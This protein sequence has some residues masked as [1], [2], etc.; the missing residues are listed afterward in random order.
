M[1]E[2]YRQKPE[3]LCQELGTCPEGLSSETAAKHLEQYG[4]NAIAEAKKKPTW[5]IFLEQF[6]DFLVIILIIAAL[7]SAFTGDLESF[8]VIIAVITMNAILGTVQTV[9]AEK[10]LSNLKKLSSPTAK[11]L[12]DGQTAILPAEE[13]TVGDV[14]LLEAGDQIPADGRLIDCASL[15]TN[16]S[17][18]TGEST[19]LEKSLDTIT[20]EVPLADRKNMVYSGGFVTYGRGA[21]VVT[22]VGM[23][24]EVG[25]IASLIQNAEAR[26]TPLQITLDQFGK[27]LSIGIMIVCAL[28]FVLSSR[29]QNMSVGG[30]RATFFAYALLN[31]MV[32]SYY[33]LIFDLGTLVLAFLATSLYFGLMAVYG[34]TTH[35]DL[36]GWGPKL[37]MGLFALIITGF[38]GMLF[39]MSFLTTVLYSAVGLVVFMLLTAYDTQKLSQMYAYYAYD[40]ELAEKASI[41]GALTLYLDFINI[42]LY[43]VRLLGMNNRRRS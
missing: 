38:V 24:T 2:H 15:Q 14:V 39:G 5:L 22:E 8:I 25:K 16:E 27:R 13:I 34:T 1:N 11:V 37:M 19:N 23:Q 9:K 36:S 10:S 28:V 18:L 6:K 42:F 4:K 35:K 20:D 40:S 30:A 12:R 29:V 31:G 17:A 41:Y 33:F 32:L 26:K 21:Y 7:I 3:E 43:V